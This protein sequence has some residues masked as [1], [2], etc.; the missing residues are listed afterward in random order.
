MK[1]ENVM[2]KICKQLGFYDEGQQAKL[3]A[4]V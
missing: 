1:M 3:Q 2:M 4:H